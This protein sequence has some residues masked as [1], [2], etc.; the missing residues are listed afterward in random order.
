M[1]RCGSLPQAEMKMTE[2]G[3]NIVHV[4]EFARSFLEPEEGKF[5]FD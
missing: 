1:L 5:E 3:R 4:V 2:A